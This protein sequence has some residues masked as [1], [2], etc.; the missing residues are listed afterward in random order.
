MVALGTT[1]SQDLEL[2][3]LTYSGPV[4]ELASNLEQ[5][6]R[7]HRVVGAVAG[8]S[9]RGD[10]AVAPAG[11]AD[12]GTR[13]ELTPDT[14]LRA[15]SLTKTMVAAAVVLA[16]RDDAGALDRPLLEWLPSTVR[17]RWRASPGLTL[18]QVLSHTSGLR[19][20]DPVVLRDLGDGDDALPA[21]AAVVGARGQAFRPGS[22][23]QYCNSGYWVAGA[24]L[25]AMRGRPF[26]DALREVVLD[27]AGMEHTGFVLPADSARGHRDGAVVVA[28]YQRARRPSGGVCTTAADVLSFG[29][30]LLA[31]R[32]LLERLATPVA[33]SLYG[34][35]YGLGLN[36]AGG[37][38]FHDGNLDGYKAR[39]L[40]APAHGYAAVFL[41][42]DAGADP[43]IDDVLGPELARATGVDLPWRRPSRRPVTAYAVVRLA[44]ARVT[45][46][47]GRG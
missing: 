22:A 21:A 34:A 27:P 13:Q 12:V 17:S 23:W 31:D 18:R 11:L 20:L 28:E 4:S 8:V 19:D 24:V 41:S 6:V 16:T 25:S 46:I 39:L 15:A 3:A 45:A 43:A 9:S 7:R 26:E 29:E 5:A 36:L 47:V 14:V 35:R 33:W 44:V 2:G 1:K 10:R 30:F 37:M 42:N 32:D 40:L 38:V